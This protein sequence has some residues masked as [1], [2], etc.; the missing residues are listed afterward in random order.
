VHPC[1]LFFFAGIYSTSMESARSRALGSANLQSES[2]PS[3][4][5]CPLLSFITSRMLPSKDRGR[6]SERRRCKLWDS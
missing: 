3:A 4:H 1:Y 6:P 5:L 2:V